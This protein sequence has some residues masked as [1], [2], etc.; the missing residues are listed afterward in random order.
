MPVNKNEQKHPSL[1]GRTC[2]TW[3][4]VCPWKATWVKKNLLTFN[5][6]LFV[7]QTSKYAITCIIS[8]AH[9]FVKGL[10]G[11]AYFLKLILEFLFSDRSTSGESEIGTSFWLMPLPGDLRWKYWILSPCVLGWIFS[12]FCPKPGHLAVLKASPQGKYHVKQWS[13]DEK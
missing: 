13:W 11:I 10:V 3:S 12:Q 2:S 8:A 5:L 1:W 6:Y 9:S 7:L 4:L